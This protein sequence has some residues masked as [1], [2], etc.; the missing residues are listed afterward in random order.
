MKIKKLSNLEIK[1]PEKESGLYKT[2]DDLPKAHQVCIVVGKR[3]SGKSTSAVNLIEKMN[4]DYTIAVSP[5]M[6]SNKE[7]MERLN[8]K[9]V[10]EDV[11]DP[12]VVNQIKKVI[13]DEAAALDRYREELKQYNAFLKK[14]QSGELIADDELL[15][16]F[17]NDSFIKPVHEFNGRPPMIAVVVDDCIGSQLYSKP[18]KLNNLST[19]S[20]HVGALGEGGAVGCS[21]FFLIQAFKCQVGGL[22]K[23]I[24]GQA[25]S[26]I[27]FK[28]QNST[29]LKDI[30]ESVSGEIGE[31]Q[32]YKVYNFAIQEPYD[33][34]FI[35][36]HRKPNHVS[37]FRKRF[38]TFII[39][40]ELE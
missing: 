10:I 27:I 8:I 4:Y 11:D 22:N 15:R 29:E 28:T 20:R 13:E 32:F 2:P 39:P 17:E 35:D 24:R 16:Y 30:A 5:T 7:L 9:H 14:L 31:E 33:F 23:V 37:M 26:M 36:L 38:D 40:E 25:T 18:R 6:G 34:L 1:P 19:L 21:L 12:S 3:N